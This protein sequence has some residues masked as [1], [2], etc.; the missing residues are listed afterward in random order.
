MGPVA[1]WR[2]SY[3]IVVS[4]VVLA[5]AATDTAVAGTPRFRVS[6]TQRLSDVC[7]LAT[8]D[9]TGDGRHD[10]VTGRFF[11]G[12][13]L[14]TLPSRG[15]G[16]FGHI[17][18]SAGKGLGPFLCLDDL[19]DIDADGRRD[20]VGIEGPVDDLDGIG[21]HQTWVAN[22]EGRGRFATPTVLGPSASL[23]DIAIA[24]VDF[25]ADGRPDVA[26]LEGVVPDWS[27]TGTRIRLYENLGRRRFRSGP[28][29]SEDRTLLPELPSAFDLL[30]GDLNRD[31][32]PDL[33]ATDPD[34]SGTPGTVL[35][36]NSRGNF[37]LSPAPA[38]FA[39]HEP[40]RLAD[41]T[42]DG[43]LD[44]LAT[45]GYDQ[46]RGGY[47]VILAAGDG[48]GRFASPQPTG[49]VLY[50]PD[51][52]K[53][54][55]IDGDSHLDLVSNDAANLVFYKGDGHGAF[56]RVGALHGT[57]G[58]WGS[59]LF[60]DFNHDHRLDIAANWSPS[61]SCTPGKPC[62]GIRVL[63]AQR[64]PA[65]GSGKPSSGTSPPIPRGLIDEPRSHPRSF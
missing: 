50:S 35:L 54:A 2:Q 44:L 4:A 15:G 18:R 10:L 39:T 38:A 47:P 59:I 63:I 37:R 3:P 31:G 61:T 36:T 62:L 19:V 30:A 22:G 27:Q 41:V 56:S 58:Q 55:D 64:Q 60:A 42:E 46:A 25:N 17:R 49:A 28:A 13:V 45:A 34:E 33:I 53:L 6:D 24:I 20:A 29:T 23:T 9:V 26:A 16:R 51:E 40:V 5:A 1:R 21:A 65:D 12:G 57:R 32:A 14:Q 11:G 48:A 8:G 43:R 52:L 7:G